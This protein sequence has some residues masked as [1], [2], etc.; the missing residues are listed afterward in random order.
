M[1]VLCVCLKT[2]Q[3]NVSRLR[4]RHYPMLREA[5]FLLLAQKSCLTNAQLCV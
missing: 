3:D 1:F 5:L 4:V 2:N